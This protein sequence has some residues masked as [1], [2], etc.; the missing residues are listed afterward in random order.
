MLTM[1]AWRLKVEP[2]RG[3]KP[4]LRTKKLKNTDIS[5]ESR[6]ALMFWTYFSY[7]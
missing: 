6:A 4:V 2:W 1:E 7:I 3:C 5:C